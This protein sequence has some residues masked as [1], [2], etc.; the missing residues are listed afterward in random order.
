MKTYSKSVIASFTAAL[1]AVAAQTS[2]AATNLIVVVTA[3]PLWTDT[4]IALATT[5]VAQ[6][7]GAAGGWAAQTS[8]PFSGPDGTNLCEDV[9]DEWISDGHQG[10]LIGFVGVNPNNTNAVF[11]D[12]PGLFVVSTNSVTFTGRAGEL[13]LGFNDA[14]ATRYPG[15]VGVNDNSGSV[16]VNVTT[17]SLPEDLSIGLAGPDILLSIPTV[18]GNLYSYSLQATTNL[19]SGSWSALASNLTSSGGLMTNYDDTALSL[20][21]RFYRMNITAVP[22][23]AAENA[24]NSAYNGFDCGWIM[25]SSLWN[26]TIWTNGLTAGTGFGPWM[27]TATGVFPSST[28]GFFIGSSTNN[29]TGSPIGI[30]VNDVSWGIYANSSNYSA[31][32]RAF[33]NGPLLVGQTFRIDMENGFVDPGGALGFAIRNSN[34]NSSPANYDSQARFQFFYLGGDSSNSYKV[35]D[36]GGLQDIGVPFTRTGLHLVFTLNTTNTYTL[37]TINNASN[38]TNNFAGTLASATNSTLDSIAVF[39]LDAGEGLDHNAFFNSMSVA[40]PVTVYDTVGTSSSPSAG[41][42][43]GGGGT[44]APGSNVTVCATANACYSFVNWTDQNN[45]VVSTTPCYS[46]TVASNETFVAN[47]VQTSYEINT[48]SSPAGGG[49]ISGG[50]PAACGSNMTV[51]A[52]ANACYNFVNWT[53]QSNNLISVSNCYSFTATTNL[54]LVANFVSLTNYTINA[55]SSPTNSGSV[56]GGGTVACGSNVTVC[57]TANGCYSFLNWTDQ[58]SNVFSTAACYNF[59]AV[60]NRT[61]VA[62]FAPISYVIGTSSSPTNG[63]SVSGGGTVACGSNVTVCATANGCYSFLNWT[64]QNSNVFSTAACYNFMAVSN[65]TLVANFAPI[66]YVIGTSSSPTNG[67]S[68]SGGGTVACGSNVTVCATAN[69]CY[70]FVNWTDQNSNVFS[71]AA[72][73][74]FMAVSNRTLVANFAPISYVI[75]TSSSPT[76]GGFTSGGGTVM[77]GSNVTVCATTNASFIFVS[78]TAQSSTNAVSTNACYSFTATTNLNLVANFAP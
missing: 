59:T 58:N 74:N 36:A 42:S 1:I 56:S 73:Y 66:S 44:V 18:F 20:P 50:G 25:S 13:W 24:A 17:V 38:A 22:R 67:G 10:Q 11:A 16:T 4:G 40:N 5:D 26:G 27:L 34:I 37:L 68:V 30:D 15:N 3:N 51:C 14:F 21:Q 71:T 75:G 65:R 52:T 35:V 23:Q 57:A 19:V 62:N 69:G 39:D 41:G 61:L 72:C 53:D 12:G 60:S 70:S 63:G 46:F 6:I 55:S 47:F 31:A 78:W 33:A 76:N 29:E 48:S 77:C 9:W 8:F 28:N 45:N 43:T 7:Y 2:R 64:D 32:Y 49:T 54:N